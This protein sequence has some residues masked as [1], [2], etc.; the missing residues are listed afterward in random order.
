M[1]QFSYEVVF[2]FSPVA[3]RFPPTPWQHPSPAGCNKQACHFR[4]NYDEIRKHGYA[5]YAL[6]ADSGTA[7]GKWQSK[8]SD[9]VPLGVLCGLIRLLQHN[10]PYS[11]LSDPKRVLIE[12]LGAK[13]GSSTTRSHFIFEKGTGKLLQ[14][15]IS[16]KAD[17]R[18]ASFSVRLVFRPLI[19]TTA[20]SSRW[21]TSRISEQM[22]PTWPVLRRC[23]FH[24][25]ILNHRRTISPARQ[26]YR[27][28]V[29][30]FLI[31]RSLFVRRRPSGIPDFL[32]T[33]PTPKK[34][35]F[36]KTQHNRFMID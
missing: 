18:Y 6:S 36:R 3:H 14:A 32:E 15:Q 4:D 2:H 34:G 33:I 1:D 10:L 16:V 9:L 30:P 29:S 21:T 26:S 12:Q 24:C 35:K 11:M 7:Q 8:V 5:V 19:V 27:N 13:N 28:V 22:V 17:D 25:T 31:T 23:H 20:T